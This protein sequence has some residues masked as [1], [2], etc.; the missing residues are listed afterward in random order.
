MEELEEEGDIGAVGKGIAVETTPCLTRELDGCPR[1][2]SPP[3]TPPPLLLLPLLEI[4]SY[5]LFVEASEKLRKSLE[6]NI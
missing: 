2:C 5:D 6:S 1:F 3:E 4:Q